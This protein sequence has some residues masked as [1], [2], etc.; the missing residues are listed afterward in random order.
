MVEGKIEIFECVFPDYTVRYSRWQQGFDRYAYFNRTNP[1]AEHP[2]VDHRGRL[3]RPRPGSGWTTG[4][5]WS[6]KFRWLASYRNAPYEVLV[7]GVDEEGRDAGWQS[8]EAKH[9]RDIGLH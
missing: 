8:V 6:G 5:R 1:N 3:R 7:Q 4:P 9:P 2:R